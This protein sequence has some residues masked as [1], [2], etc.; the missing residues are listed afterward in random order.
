MS[1]SSGTENQKRIQQRFETCIQWSDHI[2]ER[3]HENLRTHLED[4]I[5]FKYT[6]AAPVDVLTPLERSQTLLFLDK[7]VGLP[8]LSTIDLKQDGPKTIVSNLSDFKGALHDFRPIIMNT[9]D[10]I[11]FTR[12]HSLCSKALNN[13]EPKTGLSI[14]VTFEKGGDA[15][16]LFCRCLIEHK[17]ACS[18]TVEL[19]DFDYIYNGILQHA[20]ERYGKRYSDDHYSGELTYILIRNALLLQPIANLLTWHARLISPFNPPNL[21]SL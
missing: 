14:S 6:H 10:R 3:A 13:R 17:K 2:I 18:K 20:D 12:I 5:S 8:D 7:V 1:N 19:A 11:H 15:T 4:R 16:G 21:G 9:S